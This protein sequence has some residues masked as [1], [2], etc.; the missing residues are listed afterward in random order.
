MSRNIPKDP[1]L[2]VNRTTNIQKQKI[3]MVTKFTLFRIEIEQ[4]GVISIKISPS[5][6]SIKILTMPSTTIYSQFIHVD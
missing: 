3:K 5:N 4:N 6:I 2:F 1:F